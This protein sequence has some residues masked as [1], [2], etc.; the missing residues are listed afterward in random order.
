MSFDLVSEKTGG[1]DLG[2]TGIINESSTPDAFGQFFFELDEGRISGR[3]LSALWKSDD[4]PR[5]KNRARFENLGK[6]PF[7]SIINIPPNSMLWSPQE[8]FEEGSVAIGDGDV[9]I[10]Q[11]FLGD[12][13]NLITHFAKLYIERLSLTDVD[14]QYVFQ[15]SVNNSTL[16]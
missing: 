2:Q 12:R 10:L 11:V 1:F 7:S 14:F 9:V 5:I 4:V 16:E 8:G 3:I 13:Y 15:K 6:V